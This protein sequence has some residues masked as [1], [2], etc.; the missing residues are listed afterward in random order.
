MTLKKVYLEHE[1]EIEIPFYDA[2]PMGVTWHGN[3]V[4]YLEV[5]R[6]ELLD[7]LQFNYLEM[8]QSGFYW[9]IVDLRLKYVQSSYFKQIVIIKSM[10]IEYENRLK[11]EYTLRDK[12]TN[13]VLT[14]A[15]TTQVAVCIKT[16]EMC[17]ESPK[18]LFEKMAQIKTK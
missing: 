10:I 17:F 16:K 12:K 9:P 5:A 4:K 18:I 15:T 13:T 8:E 6:C 14:K 3:Y 7:K 1:T 2:D 11:I